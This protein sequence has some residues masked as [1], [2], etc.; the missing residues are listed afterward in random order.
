M[1]WFTLVCELSANQIPA[2]VIY[3]CLNVLS[4]SDCSLSDLPLVIYPCSIFSD[5]K[6]KNKTN[7]KKASNTRILWSKI[8]RNFSTCSLGKSD[9]VMISFMVICSSSHWA[10][11]ATKLVINNLIKYFKIYVLCLPASWLF[12]VSPEM[13]LKLRMWQK[14][15]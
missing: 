13:T 2:W 9:V 1:R 7:S 3:T 6:A 10:K 5:P 8:E 14:M 15:T 4:Q 12:F 11:S